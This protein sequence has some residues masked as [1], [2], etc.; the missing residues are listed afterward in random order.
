MMTFL[1][2]CS[3]DIGKNEMGEY[4]VELTLLEGS[5]CYCPIEGLPMKPPPAACSNNLSSNS[6]IKL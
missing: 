6:L 3:R 2:C 1:T 5:P 4:L